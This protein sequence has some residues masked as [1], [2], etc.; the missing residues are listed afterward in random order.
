M[1]ITVADVFY[2][3]G[4]IAFAFYIGTTL[5]LDLTIF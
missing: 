3:L 1:N 5:G 4:C 2:V